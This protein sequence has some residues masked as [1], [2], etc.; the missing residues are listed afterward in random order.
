[1]K[2][3]LLL[4]ARAVVG[5]VLAAQLAGAALFVL[6]VLVEAADA[7][8]PDVLRAAA[9][10]VPALWAQASAVLG[11]CGAALAVVRLRRQGVLLGLASLG[12]GP[13]LVLVVAGLTGAAV[14][15]L[16]SRV[17]VDAPARTGEW[18]RGDGG[19]I[20]DGEGWPDAPGGVVRPLPRATRDPVADTLNGCAAGAL[21]ATLG[22]YAG[23]APTL[24]AAALLLVTDLVARGLAERGALPTAG[25]GVAAAL[26]G[27]AILVLLRRAPL[28][29]RRWG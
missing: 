16:A 7:S 17:P 20:R 25:V 9:T 28:F 19:W 1:M 12:V 13:R 22:L 8:L 14:G 15:G 2:R 26:A 18:A 11:L 5:G 6:V 21:G 23:A 10:R 4:L 29:P 27:A 3:A 24:V